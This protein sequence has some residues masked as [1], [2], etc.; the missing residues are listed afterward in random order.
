[1]K[2]II[3]LISIL[4][5]IQSISQS[6]CD[7]L[8]IVHV[9]IDAFVNNQLNITLL[10]NNTQ[11][12]FD[13]PGFRV[14]DENDNLIGEEE[15]F[16]FGIAGES[17]HSIAFDTMAFPFVEGEEYT[18][19]LE[20]WTNFYDSLE[21]VFDVSSIL[22]P[23]LQECVPVSITF[24][25]FSSEEVSYNWQLTDYWGNITQDETL[26]FAENVGSITRNVCLDQSC[27]YVNASSALDPDLSTLYV[28]VIADESYGF[29]SSPLLDMSNDSTMVFSIWADCSLINSE[30]EIQDSKFEIYPNPA[31]DV[32]LIQS[33]FFSN[34]TYQV[35]DLNGKTILNGTSNAEIIVSALEPGLYIFELHSEG[36][37]VRKKFIKN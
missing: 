10:N 16:F 13:Y 34:F 19:K 1:M 25:E 18:L 36:H 27:F 31:N 3:L 33:E 14:Y 20:L 23:T 22:F 4:L 6:T 17:T 11:E 30:F 28:N 29:I 7:S 5:S 9:N 24:L 8:E 35:L 26:V 32:L 21:C 15:V 37:T 2:K 12:I